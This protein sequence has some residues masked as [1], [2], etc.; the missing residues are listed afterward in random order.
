MADHGTLSIQYRFDLAGGAE[1][2]FDLRLDLEKIELID[3]GRGPHDLPSWTKLAFHQCANCPFSIDSLE[4]CPVAANISP[5]IL[6]FE[7]L[8]SYDQVRLTV[9]IPERRTV[10]ETS[11][12]RA[13]SSLLGLAIAASGCPHTDFLKP[14]AR[15]HQPMASEEET[16]FRATSTYMLAQYF[17]KKNGQEADFNMEKLPGIFEELQILNTWMAKRLRAASQTDSSINAIIQLDMYAK[18]LP[19]VIKQALDE[20]RYMFIPF[21]KD[22]LGASDLRADPKSQ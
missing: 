1:E 17:R 4:Y 2:I 22:T 13:I 19:Y 6:P 9:T 21:L 8:L 11:A 20:I 14:M 10:K 18:A 7:K 12:Q 5:F 15:F 3:V 16:I